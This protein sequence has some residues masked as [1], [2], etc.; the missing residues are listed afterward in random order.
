M[1]SLAFV[2]TWKWRSDDTTV[3]PQMSEK[4]RRRV[5]RLDRSDCSKLDVLDGTQVTQVNLSCA[6]YDSNLSLARAAFWLFMLMKGSQAMKSFT[7]MSLINFCPFGQWA[8]GEGRFLRRCLKQDRDFSIEKNRKDCANN[9]QRIPVSKDRKQKERRTW[10]TRPD[11][12]TRTA[13]LAEQQ[14][15]MSW[16]KLWS[17]MQD[18]C[19]VQITIQSIHFENTALIVT[20]DA[21]WSSTD[22]LE[23]KIQKESLNQPWLDKIHLRW[24]S[25]WRVYRTFET[26]QKPVYDLV[27]GEGIIMQDTWIGI[28]I[29]LLRKDILQTSSTLR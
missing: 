16:S 7:N 18:F 12:G 8:N 17:Q 9:I 22:T 21:S 3:I 1:R 14:E 20:S 2:G 11:I 29:L 19:H 6:K 25:R 28:G 23:N 26:D 27:H 24:N 13:L 15:L 5:A 10:S 4:T